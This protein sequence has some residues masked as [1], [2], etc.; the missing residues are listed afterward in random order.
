MDIGLNGKVSYSRTQNS[1]TA[2]SVTNAIDWSVTGDVMFHLPRQWEI[3]ADCG[4]TARYGYTGLTD[5][6]EIILNASIDKTWRN[7]TLSL[8]A[9]DLL[10]QKKNIRQ[11][12][13]EN[14]VSY[15]KYNTLPTYVMLTFTYKLN[16]MGNNKAKGM[17]GMMQEM[18]EKG[19][20]RKTPPVGPP[21]FMR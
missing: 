2:G 10:H 1:L 18:E 6:N 13:G 11:V 9:Y 19:G 8:K 15:Q 16:R 7:A 21:P 20:N 17:A 14:Y 5:V 4:Y 3:A 12:V